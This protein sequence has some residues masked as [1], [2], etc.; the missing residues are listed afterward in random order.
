[1]G[2][3][4]P[5][6][7]WIVDL[8]DCYAKEYEDDIRSGKA[9]TFPVTDSLSLLQ[10]FKMWRPLPLV[11]LSVAVTE[12]FTPNSLDSESRHTTI[13][14]VPNGPHCL[15]SHMSFIIR[16]NFAG[17]QDGQPDVGHHIVERSVEYAS[18]YN[19]SDGGGENEIA[20]G[21]RQKC[22]ERSKVHLPAKTSWYHRLFS[23]E[24]NQ[25]DHGNREPRVPFKVKR[26]PIR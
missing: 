22:L 26:M 19:I 21:D 7:E 23:Y 20:G 6:V 17:T 18:Q 10:K 25:K 3:T 2:H 12:S 14:E 11:P 9:K 4:E 13:I 8:L 24:T 15:Y 16:E 1:M 5:N